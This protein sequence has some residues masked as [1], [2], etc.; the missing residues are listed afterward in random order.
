MKIKFLVI[1]TLC[2]YIFY[3]DNLIAQTVKQNQIDS[4]VNVLVKERRQWNEA[5]ERLQAIGEPVLNELIDILVDKGLD[6]WVRRKAAF[7]L[8]EIESELKIEPCVNIYTDHTDNLQVRINAC[9]ALSTENVVKYEELFL[10]YATNENQGIRMAAYGRLAQIGSDKA[11][12]FLID[13]VDGQNEMAQWALL[14]LLEPFE[15]NKVNE[16]FINALGDSTWWMT[17][18][19]IRD[20]LI[21]KGEDVLEP[22]SEIYYKQ[23]NS[24]YLRWLAMWII[25]DLGTDK[26]MPI[27]QK[28]LSDKS[29]I[30]RNEAEVALNK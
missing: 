26:K 17:N 27:L 7:T 9:N 18:E 11:I 6:S 1:L 8:S 12:N 16:K 28:A 19:F 2:L 25:K 5:S 30:I 20:V 13:E 4:L 22:L 14:R 3:F 10:F 21:T 15:S 29:W 23:E 24:D